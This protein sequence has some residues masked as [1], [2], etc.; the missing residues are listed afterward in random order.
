MSRVITVN[1]SIKDERL[2]EMFAQMTGTKAA[3]PRV[4][5]PKYNAIR[6][7][8]MIIIKTIEK[9]GSNEKMR[10]TFP[11][12]IPCFNECLDYSK[13]LTLALQY[14]LITEEQVSEDN[15]HTLYKT[16]K[17]AREVRTISVMCARLRKDQAVIND[18]NLHFIADQADCSYTPFPFSSFNFYNLWTEISNLDNGSDKIK[19]YVLQVLKKLMEKSYEIQN[20]LVSPDIDVDE[21]SS[22][23]IEAIS[24]AR[25]QLPECRQ[26]F[27]K[28]EE[29]V[30]TLKNNFSEYYKEFMVSKTPT[31]ILESFIHDVS[32][33]HKNNLKLKWQFMR[34]VNFYRKH[35]AGKIAKDSN[36]NY[37]FNTLDDHLDELGKATDE[38]EADE[39]PEP[40]D[41][42]TYGLH[43]IDVNENKHGLY[44]LVVEESKFE[45]FV[46]YLATF[47][48]MSCKTLTVLIDSYMTKIDKSAAVE[49]EGIY[50]THTIT[51]YEKFDAMTYIAKI[52]AV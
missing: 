12:F 2:S 32:K 21:F 13:N 20:I 10:K 44:I 26:A 43:H 24:K 27:N 9:F 31:S 30:G 17:E 39:P 23:L 51:D 28:I 45:E 19:E 7:A 40:E 15:I 11:D 18:M 41:E 33:S 14:H 48:K 35:S 4:I 49:I 29:A 46:K 52:S 3:D 37:I 42:K 25:A 50:R 16:C 6:K 34:I 5:I 1:K 22:V 47:T 36:L 38:K 8:A